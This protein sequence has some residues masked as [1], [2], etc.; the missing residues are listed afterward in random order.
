MKRALSVILL[1]FSYF[2]LAGGVD[3][4]NAGS[5]RVI[6]FV[7]D[8]NF[9]SEQELTNYLLETKELIRKG[10][11]LNLNILRNQYNCDRA[12]RIGDMEVLESYPFLNGQLQKKTYKGKLD[13]KLDNCKGLR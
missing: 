2:T 11:V 1:F 7:L 13:L 5:S 9:T 4:G 10:E 6:S 12:I 3:V 8:K